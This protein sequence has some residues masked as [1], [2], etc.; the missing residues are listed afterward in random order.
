M[1]SKTVI[2]VSKLRIETSTE[3]FPA[4]GTNLINSPLRNK[5]LAKTGRNQIESE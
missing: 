2:R 5:N 1:N 3:P 4:L